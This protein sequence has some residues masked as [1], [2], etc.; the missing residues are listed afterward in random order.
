MR[1]LIMAA[2]PLPLF[3]APMEGIAAASRSGTCR[4]GSSPSG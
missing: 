2:M 1:H 4:S 3:A